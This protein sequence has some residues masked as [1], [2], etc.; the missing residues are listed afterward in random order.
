MLMSLSLCTDNFIFAEILEKDRGEDFDI[1]YN[2]KNRFS[3][4]G[5][6]FTRREEQ[7]DDLSF[8]LVK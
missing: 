5:N 2:S 3:F 6:G 7:G 1:R 4:M 8:Y